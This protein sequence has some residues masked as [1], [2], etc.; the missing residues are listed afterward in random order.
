[1]VK[2]VTV[3]LK[4]VDS[5]HVTPVTWLLV[6]Q[7]VMVF[8]PLHTSLI[9]TDS[10]LSSIPSL[11]HPCCS[12]LNV[13]FLLLRRALMPFIIWP[14]TYCWGNR[15][16]TFWGWCCQHRTWYSLWDRK[17]PCWFK[18]VLQDYSMMVSSDHLYTAFVVLGCLGTSDL[19][20]EWRY[21]RLWCDLPRGG[22]AVKLYESLTFV[23]MKTIILFFL[24]WQSKY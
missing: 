6:L 17:P 11:P 4:F 3:Q 21:T 2:S 19:Y 5:I 15:I 16:Q 22:R 8:V 9:L 10:F 18:A 12:D 7:P 1:M 13:F 23:Y 20:P 14:R 24:L